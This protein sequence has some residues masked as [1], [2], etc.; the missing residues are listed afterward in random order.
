LELV[1]KIRDTLSRRVSHADSSAQPEEMSDAA[2]AL[3]IGVLAAPFFVIALVLGLRRSRRIRRFRAFRQGFRI[4]E[5]EGA[6]KPIHIASEDALLDA[7]G[8]LRCRCGA[9][10]R[11]DG[12]GPPQQGLIY[13]GRH[14]IVVT[15]TCIACDAARDVYFAPSDPC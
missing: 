5:G 6:D 11:F 2:A 10:Y 14:L 13:D 9:A 4:A 12:T 15:I 3:V 1:E 8:S 7:V